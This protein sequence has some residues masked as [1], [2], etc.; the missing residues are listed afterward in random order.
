MQEKCKINSKY[1]KKKG[2]QYNDEDDEDYHTKLNDSKEKYKTNTFW[3]RNNKKTIWGSRAYNSKNNSEKSNSIISFTF[4]KKDSKKLTK[5]K[6]I[7]KHLIDFKKSRKELKIKYFYLWYDKIYNNYN[8]KK[9]K[10]KRNKNQ[11]NTYKSYSIYKIN[12]EKL[13]KNAKKR[14]KKNDHYK[15]DNSYYSSTFSNYESSNKDIDYIP[16]KTKNNNIQREYNNKLKSKNKDFYNTVKEIR[17][18]KVIKEEKYYRHS[19]NNED[20]NNKISLFNKKESKEKRS[21]NKNNT[22]LLYIVNKCIDR[23]E[24]YSCFNK[25]LNII[26]SIYFYNGKEAFNELDDKYGSKKLIINPI[27]I[28]LLKKIIKVIMIINL[29]KLKN[30]MI[31]NPLLFKKMIK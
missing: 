21:K 9:D 18:N 5:F 15:R 30:I 14:I 20:N 8:T 11:L 28:I 25:W 27:L 19:F 6:N 12:Y 17:N 29:I 16:I 3:N 7:I 13:E 1:L 26:N 22:K 10:I 23:K 31:I 24:K 4:E 2:K